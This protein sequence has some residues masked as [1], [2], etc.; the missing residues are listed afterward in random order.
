MAI[1]QWRAGPTHSLPAFSALHAE[2]LNNFL[3]PAEHLHF[4]QQ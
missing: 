1:H 2:A 4:A 3:E